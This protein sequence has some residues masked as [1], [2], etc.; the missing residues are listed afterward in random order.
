M[1]KKICKRKTI[2]IKSLLGVLLFAQLG[3]A[4]CIK[5]DADNA[6]KY[7]YVVSL[8]S[9]Q[10][11]DQYDRCEYVAVNE[12]GILF[13]GIQ[14]SSER[15]LFFKDPADN[16]C[17]SLFSI[18][19]TI[20]RDTSMRKGTDDSS[21]FVLLGNE[22]D[23]NISFFIKIFS[24]EGK[25]LNETILKS[26]SL[27]SDYP[28]N[29][30]PIHDGGYLVQTENFLY[31]F[32][33]TGT[34]I[35]SAKC[36]DGSFKD[37]VSYGTNIVVTYG[38]KETYAARFEYES[39]LFLNTREITGNGEFISVDNE[40]LYYADNIGILGINLQTDERARYLTFVD[41]YSDLAMMAGISGNQNEFIIF[42]NSDDRTIINMI[43]YGNKEFA[44]DNNH[45]EKTELLLYVTNN[46]HSE[47]IKEY[48][49]EF[50]KQ[51]TKYSIRL[52]KSAWDEESFTFAKDIASGDFP[53]ILC[54]CYDS[55][56]Y[57]LLKDGFFEDLNHFFE[58][59]NRYSCGDFDAHIIDIYTKDDIL[60]SIPNFYKLGVL[61][62]H[63]SALDDGYWDVWE[64]L[65]WG[66][67]HPDDMS[68]YF[69]REDVYN[70]CMD[71][72]IEQHYADGSFSDYLM[73]DEFAAFC[74]KL[75]ELNVR[76]N[77]FSSRDEIIQYRENDITNIREDYFSYLSSLAFME[78]SDAVDYAIKSY[79]GIN[80]EPTVYISSSAMGICSQS[81]HKEGAYDFLEF[82]LDC[83]KEEKLQ[84]MHSE[85]Y[86]V[87]TSLKR[88]YEKD[89]EALL[90]SKVCMHS[91]NFVKPEQI[92]AVL[93]LLPY[94]KL[95]DYTHDELKNLIWEDLKDYIYHDKDF[96]SVIKS[97]ESR[98]K[99]YI[100]ER[101]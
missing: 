15:T 73:S 44:T 81:N 101:E 98:T 38:D 13:Y 46:V 20:Y 74:E 47:D 99:I 100:T 66:D 79:P 14:E 59:S 37:L 21:I 29:V 77:D 25:F 9:I 62:G 26:E 10:V 80:D 97:I 72:F 35:A 6:Q 86:Y 34:E 56:A 53:D 48:V 40:M 33:D 84:E 4:G 57:S 91:D 78:Y 85:G 87:F 49:N 96:D 64:F 83:A 89:K 93:N 41:N 76:D 39:M 32:S 19:D 8:S 90:A 30:I 45:A 5:E 31:R 24:K 51:S 58:Y 50:N 11:P 63:K 3:L 54:T 42:E 23:G 18:T 88:D 27:L 75:K 82:Y 67:K 94:S 12:D 70:L 69:K 61:C 16:S 65:D 36:P 28:I 55:T 60:F 7:D 71:A 95:K 2:I 22:K 1:Y 52:K 68:C 92:E 17:K 43:R